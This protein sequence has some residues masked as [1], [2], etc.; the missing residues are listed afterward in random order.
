MKSLF[1]IQNLAIKY[2]KFSLNKSLKS[3]LNLDLLPNYQ[4]KTPDPNINYMLYAHVP[5]CH[6]F[7]PYCSFHKYAYDESLAKE[8]FKNLRLEMEQIYKL[9]YKFNSMYVGGGTTL[10][11]ESELIKTLE[12]AK[13]LF[14]IDEISCESD[15]NHIEIQNL[16]RFKGLIKRLSIGVQSFNDEILK[17]VGRYDKFGSSQTLITKLKNAINVL[18]I[19]SIDLIFNFPNQTKDMLINDINL[20]KSI[21]ADQITFYPL[22]KSSL[23]KDKIASALGVSKN[24]NEYEF[25]TI[26]EESFKDYYKSNAWSYA[27]K[28]LAL[29]D[30]Y[31]SSKHEYLGIGSG[32]FSF[33]NGELFI[34]AFNLN[35]YNSKIQNHQSSIIANCKFNKKERIK[36]LFLTEIFS[37][38]I[39]IS[40]FNQTN[41]TDLLKMLN[42]ELKLLKLIKAIK[43]QNNIIQSTQFGRYLWLSLM[44]EFYTGMDRVRAIF[45]DDSKIKNS[46]KINI[47]KTQI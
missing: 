42:I 45:K 25:Y 21:D 32:G 18:P 27:K 13:K 12:L 37:G 22:M 44:K 5:F 23:T 15:P 11:N 19:T 31:V 39:D 33:L 47:M 2:A 28:K 24:D 36:Y 7:C 46:S 41:N 30:E 3:Q 20:A 4:T 16:N 34:N 10:I 8:Y 14:N 1:L 9:G 38:F 40:K 35:E 17:K 43:I 26:I 29:N 6:T